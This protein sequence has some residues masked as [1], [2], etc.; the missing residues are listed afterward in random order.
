MGEDNTLMVQCQ[1][2]LLQRYLIFQWRLKLLTVNLEV[3]NREF[4][5]MEFHKRIQH[6][7]NKITDIFLKLF[8][9]EIWI[10]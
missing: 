7:S 8:K 5:Q 3:R 10:N 1:V 9:S 2:Y 6:V 4:I